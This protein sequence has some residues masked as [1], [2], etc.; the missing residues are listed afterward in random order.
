MGQACC[1][2][3]PDAMVENLNP[4]DVKRPQLFGAP[5]QSSGEEDSSDED[6]SIEGKFCE[7]YL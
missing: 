2:N 5:H 4:A 7:P 6:F 3:D 1:A